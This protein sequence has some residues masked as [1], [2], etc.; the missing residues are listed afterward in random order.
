MKS[1]T[2]IKKLS[3]ITF[4][5]MNFINIAKAEYRVFQYYVKSRLK[6]PTDQR[7]YL[8]TSTL[9]P[10]SYL[11]YHGGNTSLKVDLL[12]SWT[13]KG[14]TGNYQELCRGPEENAG[15]FAQNESN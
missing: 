3:L 11:S 6:L 8:V 9:D 12:R 7:G 15:V 13:C 2:F 10:V 4:L 14:H 5:S 1:L